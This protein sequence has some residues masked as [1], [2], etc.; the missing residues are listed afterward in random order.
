MCGLLLQVRF[1]HKDTGVY[2]CS[3]KDYK[4]GQPIHGQ[5]EIFGLQH[6]TKDS[7]WFAAEGVYLP[8][9][10]KKGSKAKGS[11]DNKDEL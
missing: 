9:S 11:K 1:K 8:R 7:E 6:K 2:M 4:F 3:N 5:Q 10:D